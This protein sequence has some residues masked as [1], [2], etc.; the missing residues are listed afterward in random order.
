[1]ILAGR[2]KF[3]GADR[4]SLAMIDDEALSRRAPQGQR[5]QLRRDQEL[6]LTVPHGERTATVVLPEEF[7]YL[8]PGD[9]VRISPAEQ[10]VRVLYRRTSPHNVLFFTEN[11]NSRCLMCSQPPRDALDEHLI[12]DILAIIPWMDEATP[13]LG[14]TGGEPTLRHGKLAE[15]LATA[16]AHLPRT[17]IHLLSNGRM[18]VY[19]QFAAQLAAVGH[20]DFM[21]G[22]PLYGDTSATHDFIVQAKGAFDQTIRGLMNLGAADV[23]VEIRIVIHRQS[24]PRLTSLCRFIARNL[25][26]AGQIVLMGLEPTGYAR[27]NWS[28]L[29]IDPASYQDELGRAVEILEAGGLTARLYNHPLCLVPDHLRHIAARSISDWKKIFLAPC[30]S[31]S[32][33][34]ECCGFFASAAMRHSLAVQPL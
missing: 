23:P 13:A 18:F 11:C 3:A 33:R 31:C 27:S 5:G 22:V 30:A 12:E 32:R 19:P 16:K 7:R 34:R 6:T 17:S 15:V 28:E 26:F 24:L 14:I 21:I 20:P 1:M 2:A 29:W 8:G 25:S 4:T 10:F 9:I